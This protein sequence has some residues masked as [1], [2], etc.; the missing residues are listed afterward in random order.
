MTWWRRV[1]VIVLL[2]PVIAVG[3]LVVLFAGLKGSAN[4]AESLCFEHAMERPEYGAYSMSGELWPP[5]FECAIQGTDVPTV[6]ERHPIAAWGMFIGIVIVP[7]WCLLSVFVGVWWF[8]VRSR[9][10]RPWI[11]AADVAAP[12]T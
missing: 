5:S 12:Q 10:R 2:L 4:Y 7:L 6:V 8:L 11:S 9:D 1:G 3:G